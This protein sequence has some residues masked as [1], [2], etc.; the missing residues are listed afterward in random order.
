[1]EI[2]DMV[3]KTLAVLAIVAVSVAFTVVMI[4][5]AFKDVWRR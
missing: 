1:M 3:L 4:S 5:E 2:W